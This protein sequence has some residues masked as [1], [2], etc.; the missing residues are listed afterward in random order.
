MGLE[1]YSL[2]ILLHAASSYLMMMS[3][4]AGGATVKYIAEFSALGE[5]GCLEKDDRVRR[6]RARRGRGCRRRTLAVGAPLVARGLLKVPA[7]LM[8]T[9]IFVLRC[10]ALPEPFSPP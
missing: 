3:L 4:G 1:T 6:P 10:A 9:A 8:D 2:Y 7:P 5:R